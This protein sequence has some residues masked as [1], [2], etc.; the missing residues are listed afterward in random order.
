MIYFLFFLTKKL[1]FVASLVIVFFS[2]KFRII[3]R[4]LVV[5]LISVGSFT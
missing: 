3:F 2:K 4:L 5:G 1:K